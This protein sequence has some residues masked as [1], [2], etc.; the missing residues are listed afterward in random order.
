M[1]SGFETFHPNKS[2]PFRMICNREQWLPNRMDI[3]EEIRKDPENGTRRL[4]SEYKLGLMALARRFCQDEGDAEELV[5][6]TLAEVVSSIDRYAE[7]SAFFAWMARILVRR[8]GH[9]TERKSNMT[10]TLSPEIVDAAADPAAESRIFHDVDAAIL[11]D[12]I[13]GLPK[14]IRNTL[15][16]HYFMDIPVREAAKVLSVPTGTIAWRL[17]Y[18]RLL[19]AAKLGA[20]AKKPV[21]KMLLLA[22][23]LAT[24]TAAGAAG[25]AMIR[26]V[27]T[28]NAESL[29]AAESPGIPEI[30]ESPDAPAPTSST[31]QPAN[32]RPIPWVD[33]QTA[34]PP[35]STASQPSNQQEV[36]T[37]NTA[38]H[39][40]I[41]AAASLALAAPTSV[42]EIQPAS[43]P[44]DTRQT[45]QAAID[46]AAALSP[47]GT[48]ALGAGTFEINAELM[49]TN[50]VA[51]VGQGWDNTTIQQ[52]A[53]GQR[54]ATLKDGSRLEGVTV[55]GG[56]LTAN[57]SHGAGVNV[58]NGTI[59]W[60]RIWHNQS[61]GR[62]IH[63]AGVHF[64]AGGGTIDHSIVAFNQAGTYTSSGGGIGTYNTSG[65]FVIDT[66]LV[67]GNT[68][69]VTDS[70]GKGGG[71][72]VN[73]GNPTVTIR[74]TTI[75]GNSSSGSGGGFYNGSYG[76]KVTLV[77]TLVAGNAADS[78]ADSHDGTLASGS[79]NNLLSG[80][81][82][83]VDSVNYDYHLASGSPAINAGT[84]YA[85]IGNDLD[86]AAFAATPSI[87]C[88]EY[89]GVLMVDDPAFSPSSGVTFNPTIDITLTCETD[90]ATI[91]YT[92]DGTDPTESSTEYTGPIALSATTTIRAR[93]YKA[94]MAASGV[95]EATYTLGAP[96]PPELGEVTVTPRATA[97]TVSGEILSVGN[98]LATTCDVWF[99]LG[100]S[101]AT[102]GEA[103]LFASGVTTSFEFAIPGLATETTYYYTLTV[104][105][106]AQVVQSA[107]MS[108]QFTTT[109]KQA[110]QPVVG[111]PAATRN[112]IQEEI[113]A[114]ALESPAGT[115]ALGEGLFEIDA[116]L[117]VTGGVTVA[118]QG[119][120][121]TVVKQT[122]VGSNARCATVSGGAKIEGVTL[123]G[124]HTRAKFEDG[125]GTL[126]DNGT[127]S[128]CC[129]TNNQTGD[130][131][132]AGVTVNNIYGAGVRIKSGTVDHSI[133]AGNTAY[134]NG[135]GNSHGGG[136]GI[137]NPT[138][139]VLVDTCLFYGNRAPS[140]KG[141]A[142]YADF[143][144]N[145]YLLT[146]RNT[147][148]ANNTAS[149]TGG[150]VYVAE[151]YAA[152]KFSFA[153]ANSILADNVSGGEGADPNLALPSDDRIVSG[154]A[155]KS[156]GNLFA[157]GT[158]ALGEG[159]RSVEGSGTDW[160]VD[161]ANGDYHQRS[162]SI[163]SGAAT[164]Y[165][166]IAEDLD[167]A[168]R[169]GRPT[170]GCY[171]AP[172]NA[173]VILFR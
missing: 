39:V 7:Q 38:T 32:R 108:G 63:G 44:A 110:L 156:F 73:M 9:D 52:T 157:N 68:A 137:Q 85:G 13:E 70:A 94:G 58:D 81:P 59:S 18:A 98:N 140:G 21:V 129:I 134:A 34:Q 145:H 111:D 67:H 61:T 95:V 15:V 127:I 132:W 151:Y 66:C 29:P 150:G 167:H 33:G 28:D 165:E 14:E 1:V 46:A 126:V 45:I 4:E 146:V 75:A 133:I 74:N 173:I 8:H 153:L 71:I 80:D 10:V 128:W 79:S 118:G 6:S 113:D 20:A 88:Y 166:G 90:A 97:A 72:C 57:W 12:A 103:A 76:N 158:P 22:L 160:F 161:A 138:G 124:G 139:T 25:V 37:M 100:A 106:N 143:G 83:F 136:L 64:A 114:A 65:T 43:T 60:C 102:L 109:A 123:T 35:S 147:T 86:G 55:T 141:G 120:E 19:L 154:Y 5:N 135:G 172:P 48:V 36:Q 149:D 56:S 105:N 77:N 69:S 40:S 42:A 82:R 78:D 107:S 89:F 16:M 49:V 27:S 30:Q 54:V 50:G 51:L 168:E 121:K 170:A 3:V 11:R 163:A 164:W 47:A 169:R 41:L 162:D 84:T 112:R 144:N 171:E 17:H 148:I 125:A 53:N 31:I 91:R 130:A 2:R 116:Q 93:A 117:M 92:L 104:S 122:A 26:S 155:A 23:A 24:L 96:T 152:N 99:A 115:V 87:G 101:S 142:I 62:N 159:S 119:W 131:A